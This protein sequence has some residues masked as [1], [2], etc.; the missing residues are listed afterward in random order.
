[1]HVCPMFDGPKPHVGGPII[2]PC[3]VTVLTGGIPQAR[4]TDKCVCAGPPDMIIK[5]SA[6]VMVGG[7]PAARMGDTTVHGG[8][9]VMGLPT[10]LI[11]DA[12][13]GGGAGGG[14]G[15]GGGSGASG[16]SAIFGMEAAKI[17]I[18]PA[19]LPCMQ[20]AAQAGSGFVAP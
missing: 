4:V 5:G 11:G 9:V 20:S 18:N 6:T 2:P 7:L 10:V 14:G 15:G 16:G 13:S 12:G 1:M 19:T 8:T 17:A 3:E